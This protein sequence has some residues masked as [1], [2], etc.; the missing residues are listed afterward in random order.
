MK[1]KTTPVPHP[2]AAD[3]TCPSTKAAVIWGV[4]AK[5]FCWSCCGSYLFTLTA[6][7]GPLP[8]SPHV[9]EAAPGG[10]C[11]HESLGC[12]D[13][14]SRMCSAAFLQGGDVD[15][16]I[17][18]YVSCMLPASLPIQRKLVYWVILFAGINY[19]KYPLHSARLICVQVFQGFGHEI[20][21]KEG[22][23]FLFFGGLFPCLLLW[24]E[25]S[26]LSLWSS[27]RRRMWIE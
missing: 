10:I 16:V 1:L 17:S 26:C 12:G 22:F 6:T 15:S 11:N 8:S 7:S 20:R 23:W 9:P 2:G 21:G 24:K 27:D 4:W 14:L 3:M 5:V 18:P 25:S 19:L 13:S